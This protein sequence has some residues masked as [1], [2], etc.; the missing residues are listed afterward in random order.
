V[1]TIMKLYWAVK[2]EVPY[3]HGTINTQITQ[4]FYTNCR[5][6]SEAFLF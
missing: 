3:V 2:K 5:I 1:V 4:N 6:N